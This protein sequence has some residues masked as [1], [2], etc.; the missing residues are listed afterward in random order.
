MW[1]LIARPLTFALSP[2]DV[3]EKTDVLKQFDKHVQSV[4]DDVAAQLDKFG[5]KAKPE[6]NKKPIANLLA[7]SIFS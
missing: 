5:H 3:P 4:V 2:E 7:S 6:V 1:S